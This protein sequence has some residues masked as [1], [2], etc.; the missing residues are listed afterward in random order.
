MAF[1]SVRNLVFLL[2]LAGA[3]LG[4]GAARATDDP[5][6][7]LK[8][9][10]QSLQVGAQSPEVTDYYRK[11]MLQRVKALKT[12]DE[13]TRALSLDEWKPDKEVF[14]KEI[15]KINLEMRQFVADR[16][17]Q[18]VQ[19]IIQKGDPN[20]RLAVANYIAEIGPN[21]PA[22]NPDDKA[23][24]ARTLTPEVIR[25]TRDPDL[26]V[27]QEALRALGNL[28]AK[29]KDAAPVF[30]EVLERDPEVGPRRLAADG[31]AQMIRVVA[32]LEK[33]VR[34][35]A[36]IEATK[37]ELLETLEVAIRTVGVG[38][39]DADTEVR[40]V[41]LNTITA[42]AQAVGGTKLVEDAYRS[43]DFP[44]VGQLLTDFQK[45][46]IEQ[47]YKDVERELDD[48]RPVI[49]VLREQNANIRFALQSPSPLVQ[50]AVLHTLEDV[51]I[52]RAR[53]RYR[54]RSL[55]IVTD[56][57]SGLKRDPTK[58]LTGMDP[59][60]DVVARDLEIIASY[61]KNGDLR[62]RRSAAK[63][64]EVIEE[65]SIKV[66]NPIVASL[67]DP[68]RFIRLNALK[69]IGYFP[70]AKVA[71]FVTN[72]A[73]LLED[74]DFNVRNQAAFTLEALGDGAKDALPTVARAILRGDAECRVAAMHVLQKMSSSY[75]KSAVPSLIECLSDFDVRVVIAG[76]K[77][78]DVIGPPALSAVPT[79]R[80]L[81]G[82]EEENV[83]RAA[84]AAMLSILRTE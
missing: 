61:L 49:Q 69:T 42:A 10:V 71:P 83:R 65:D 74:Q 26:G 77:T 36:G 84:S 48:I 3:A 30:R 79:L 63:V 78:L 37:A 72:V 8:S 51:G 62:I 56:E 4:N 29:I 21:I 73:A 17:V 22:V 45:K 14:D 31:L 53:I 38:I 50:L 27:R 75:S 59:L 43:R 7:V 52:I 47:K 81:L 46:D 55:P 6:E 60:D 35:V 28:N 2:A 76:C 57:R 16:L 39:R 40:V 25:L 58:M 66:I 82:H 54:V 20:A 18:E 23:G 70:P 68:D 1:F 11:L 80:N 64:L 67:R 32:H 34:N 19:R 41:S 44:P 15:K 9:T 5:V 33:K 12:V 24:F 13:L